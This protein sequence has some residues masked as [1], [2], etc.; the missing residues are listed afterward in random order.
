MG[1]QVLAFN[2]SINAN[3]GAE[4][5]QIAPSET[6]KDGAAALPSNGTGKQGYSISSA[7]GKN[8]VLM[9]YADAGQTGGV[10]E[11]WLPKS[12]N[13]F[14]RS[15]IFSTISWINNRT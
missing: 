12:F 2:K 9:L 5:V 7:D 14:R 11:T 4:L 1:P 10:V 15:P 8:I 13:C 3:A 6:V